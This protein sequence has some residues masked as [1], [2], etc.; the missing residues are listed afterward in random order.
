M[1]EKGNGGKETYVVKGGVALG[2]VLLLNNLLAVSGVERGVEEEGERARG[3]G[4]RKGRHASRARRKGGGGL[5]KTGK[6][7]HLAKAAG[8]GPGERER[9]E[10]GGMSEVGSFA[11]NKRSV[12]PLFRTMGS[13]S[14]AFERYRSRK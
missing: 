13:N 8:E 7:L 4:R 14:D 6:A 10:G 3:G 1:S 5:D 2:L 11:G 9:G 12:Y